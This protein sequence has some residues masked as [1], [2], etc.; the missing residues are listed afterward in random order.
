MKEAEHRSTFYFPYWNIPGSKFLI[1]RLRR[2]QRD[3]DSLKDCLDDLI[4]RAKATAHEDDLEHLQAR[5][6]SKVRFV[7]SVRSLFLTS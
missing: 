6:Y 7:K 5:D 1:P 3:L 2:F 4:D